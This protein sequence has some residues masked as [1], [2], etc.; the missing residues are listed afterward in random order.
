M[1]RYRNL[2]H[3]LAGIITAVSSLV[4]WVLPLVG[5]IFFLTYEVDEDWHI[6][7]KAYHDI[8]EAMIGFF[9]ATAGLISWR[10]LT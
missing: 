3:Y 4:S 5:A 1:W 7:D 10:F 8:L 9:V 6:R 2:A